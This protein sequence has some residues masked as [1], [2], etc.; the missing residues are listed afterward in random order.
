[1]NNRIDKIK[2]A[3]RRKY[4]N[5]GSA[6]YL[7]VM[8]A[9]QRAHLYTPGQD[10]R[11]IRREWESK[12]ASLTRK[13]KLHSQTEEVFFND[14]QELKD[15]M[16]S[17]FPGSFVNGTPGYDNEFRLA[18]A[19]KSLS[20][21]LKHLWIRGELGESTPP[22][23]PIDGVV[24]KYA[25]CNDAWTKVNSWENEYLTHL[26]FIKAKAE[27][28]GF[29]SLPEWELVV[30]W[31]D[32]LRREDAKSNNKTSAKASKR[33]NRTIDSEHTKQSVILKVYDGPRAENRGKT[34]QIINNSKPI[35]HDTNNV[36]V[37]YNAVQ[38]R[39]QERTYHRGN[40]LRGKDTIKRLIEDNHWRPGQIFPCE[41]S[42]SVDGSHHYLI[43]K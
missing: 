33:T 14:V 18:H 8:A 38:F 21:C 32:K 4:Q 37:E 34:F 7:G 5:S 20:I 24:L 2:E 15:H 40:T 26:G 16:N 12:L 42:V 6:E 41:F 25:H 30:W 11:V 3:F 28:D 43:L 10:N 17:S 9:Y 27:Q 29:Q 39:A 19:Q 1:M 31:R 22:V 35:P 36:Y 13:Y 23:C